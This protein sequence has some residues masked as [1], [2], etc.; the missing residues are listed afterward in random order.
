M[1]FSRL[2]FI[3]FAA[4]GKAE[5]IELFFSTLFQSY[6]EAAGTQ[7]SAATV[8]AI[9]HETRLPSR[10]LLAF[11]RDPAH[12]RH[13]EKLR[14]DLEA[15][16]DICF[17]DAIRRKALRQALEH[18]WENIP[19]VERADL[20]EILSGELA[21]DLACTVWYA[22]CGDYDDTASY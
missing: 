2:L 20:L 5:P 6:Y 19:A 12:P 22:L 13:P 1:R 18:Y 9:I 14:Q 15:L 7:A 3:S 11:Y 4:S 17:A 8:S 21:H 16:L 10:K